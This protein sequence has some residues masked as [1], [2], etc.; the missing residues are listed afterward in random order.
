[1][2]NFNILTSNYNPMEKQKK[3]ILSA[4]TFVELIVAA[5]IIVILSAVWFSSYVSYI[6]DSRDTQRKSD[7]AQVT[8]ALKINK[9][10]DTMLFLGILSL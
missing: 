1:M 7:L 9:K 3:H 8:S 10:D 4:F 6:A 2:T 5:T